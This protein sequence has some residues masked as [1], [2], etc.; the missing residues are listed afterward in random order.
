MLC[1]LTG[2]KPYY[3]K[4][5]KDVPFQQKTAKGDAK[6]ESQWTPDE[7]RVVVQDQRLKIIIMSCLPDDI[8]ESV[9]SCV[10]TK[11]TWT[12]L[13]HSFEGPSDTKENRIMDLKLEYQ[14]FRAKST[15]SLS[16]TYTRYKTLLNELAN[17]GGHLSKHEI[18]VGF[19]KSL[20]EKWLTFSQGLRNANHTQTFDLADIYKRFVYEDNLIQRRYSDT[21][22]VLITTLSSSAISTAFFSNN[23]IQDFLENSDDEVDERSSGEYLRDLDVEYQER[24]LLSSLYSNSQTNPK[25]QKDYKAEYKKMKAKLALLEATPSSPQNPKTFQLKNKG[26]VGEIF[27]CDEKEVSDDEEA[28]QVK[29][30][31][32]LADDELTIGKSH[33]RNGK[34]PVKYLGVPLVPSRLLYRDCKELMEKVKGRISEMKKGRAKVAWEVVCLPKREG[35]L[36]FG[37]W[38]FLIGLLLRLIY[39]VFLRIRSPYGSNGFIPISSM[40]A[41]FGKFLFGV[42]CLGDGGKFSSWPDVW[43]LKYSD[44]GTVGVPHVSDASD[45]L[46]WKDLSNVDVGFSVATVWECIHPRSDEVECGLQ[47][48][49]I[50][51]LP[52]IPS[53]LDAIV[54]FLSLM[55]KMRSARS[56]ISKLVFAASCYFIWQERNSMFFMKKKRSQDQVIDVIKSTVR[57]KLLSM[58]IQRGRSMFRWAGL[59]EECSPIAVLFFPSSRFFPLGFSWEGFLRRQCRLAVYTHMLL[60]RNVFE[61]LCKLKWFFPIGVLVRKWSQKPKT[62]LRD[63]ILTVNPE[64]QD[65]NESLETLN[66]PQS[67]KDSEAEFLTPLP[68]LKNLQGAY[69]SLEVMSLTFQPHSSKE[70][71]GLGYWLIK[72]LRPKPII[73]KPQ[74]KCELCH[75]TNHSTDDCYRILYCMIC[76]REDHRTSDHEMYIASLIKSE[77][78]KAHPY[79]YASTSKQILKA[80]AK[81][82][83]HA[84]IVVSMITDRDDCRNYPECEICGSYDHETSGHNRVIYIRGGVLAESSQ[85]NESSIK[86]KC[87]TCGSTVHFTS[88]HNEFDHFKRETHQGALESGCSRSMTGVKSYLHK[89][90]EQPSPKV[91]FGDNSSCITDGYGSINC[92]A[93][94]RNDVYVLDMSSLTPNGAC[95]FAK[96]SE[97]VNWLW[98][99]RLSHLNF[100][101]INKLAKQNK[102]LGLPF[103]VYSKDKPCTTCEKEKHHRASFKTKQNFSIRKCLHLLHMD[104]FGPVSPMSINHEKYTLVIVDEY[105]RERIPHISYFHVFGCPVFIHNH[106]DHLDKFDAKADDGYFLGYSSVSKAFRVYNT[107]R[108]Q[109]KKTYHVTFDESMKAISELTQENHVPEVIVPN[110]HD[111]PLTKDIED[112]PD[113]INTEGTHEQ[114]V[115]DDQMITQPT[116]VPSGNNTEVSR[117]ITEPLVPDVTQSHIPN[118]ASTIAMMEAIRIFLAF[119]TYMNFKVYQMDVKSAFLNGKLKEEVYVKQP[120]GFESSEFSDYVCK[121][122]KALYGLKQAPRACYKLCKQ[123]EKLMTK[124]FEMSMM[125]EL[126][127]FIGLQIKQDDK[128]ISICQE[129]YTKNLLKKYDIFDSSSVKTPVVPSNN[130]GPGLAGKPVNETSYRGMIGSLMYLTATRPDIQFSTVLCARYQSNSKESH[131]IAVRN[132]TQTRTMLAVTWTEKALQVPVKY[133]VKNWFV[134]KQH[135]VAM[136][137]AEVEYVAAVGCCASII[138]MK[139][140]LSDYDIH[141]KI[142]P[143]F[144]DNTSAIAISNNPVLHSRTKHID[145]RYHFIRDHI[146]K[147]DIELHFIPIEYQLISSLNPWMNRLSPES[148][149]RHV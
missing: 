52:N 122:D 44:L 33:A 135:S 10:S 143:I 47:V 123:F 82:F 13:V 19:V 17:D 137:S 120:S 92:G 21:K 15:E 128:G 5:I 14:T 48:F 86:V 108:Q 37:D 107:R 133:L 105:S 26:L 12:D 142:V 88:D 131:L 102:V 7:R 130:L 101:N 69:P 95:F 78:Y 91:V 115:Q 116:D 63:S 32:A 147:E 93:P 31:M 134:G 148:R 80:K 84:H 75:C 34:L 71:P 81:P 61:A 45:K 22:K 144:C 53:G 99:K 79:Q 72:S 28:T 64:S 141:Y 112:P 119:A 140:Q 58:Q 124:K 11:E 20:P 16:H 35:G 50:S 145:I 2:M 29:V 97:S 40:G 114:N 56:V 39:G 106:K 57:L 30:L 85:S 1:Y 139:R 149:I 70:R 46:V 110:E 42:R 68:P 18:N 41:L 121:L 66:T 4:C 60:Q 90:V 55:A 77:N 51:R 43:M 96:A 73:Q 8:M 49:P 76:K 136:S 83:P 36:A 24:A 27:D 132:N 6:S 25:I 23:V 125:G 59:K 103:L 118:Q 38:R 117:S 9:I 98:H 62:G 65:V 129:Q 104:L 87:N 146:L 111:V 126:T 74:L 89:Y 109:I 100:K 138:W 67:S 54:D 127:Y 3:L 94:R 113:L